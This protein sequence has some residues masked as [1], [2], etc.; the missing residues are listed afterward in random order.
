MTAGPLD[1]RPRTT[2][3]LSRGPRELVR[4]PLSCLTP[5]SAS[6]VSASSTASAPSRSGTIPSATRSCTAQRAWRKAQSAP[7][8]GPSAAYSALSHQPSAISAPPI[9]NLKSQICNPMPL[10]RAL[11]SPRLRVPP[12]PIRNLNHLVTQ[13][14]A[15]DGTFWALRDIS[16]EVNRGEVLR[17]ASHSSSSAA[18]APAGQIRNRKSEIRNQRSSPASPPLRACL[19]M[20]RQVASRPFADESL[21]LVLGRWSVVHGPPLAAPAST[22]N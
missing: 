15:G 3:P 10:L 12:F 17:N 22:P 7:R 19:P 9:C 20:H 1:N 13:L 4:G 11:A 18:T 14:P 21:P 16:F 5:S 8:P 2:G 6:K